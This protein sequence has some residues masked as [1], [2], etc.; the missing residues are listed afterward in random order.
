MLKVS[1]FQESR[2]KD[3]RWPEILIQV[4]NIKAQGSYKTQHRYSTAHPSK[5]H[6]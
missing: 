2:R 4:P 6:R 1:E 5:V 3:R